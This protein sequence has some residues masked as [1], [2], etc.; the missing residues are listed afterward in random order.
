MRFKLAYKHKERLILIA[1]IKI[2]KCKIVNTICTVALEVY[3][4]AVSVEN[5]AVIAVRS[6]FKAVCCTPILI[7][8]LP[9]LRN[10]RFFTMNTD[11]GITVRSKMPFSYVC[12]LITRIV[13]MFCKRCD[14][15]GKCNAVP[16]AS[17]LRSINT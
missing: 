15:I 7:L 17:D 10:G 6:K 14:A 4:V 9:V 13:E 5:I 16:I 2:F 11:S 1:V 12:S 8:T 3:L